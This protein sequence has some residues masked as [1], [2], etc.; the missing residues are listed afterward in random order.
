MIEGIHGPRGITDGEVRLSTRR[1]WLE[2][3]AILDN[4]DSEDKRFSPTLRYL[5]AIHGLNLYWAQ[6]IA[7][8]YVMKRSYNEDF[9]RAAL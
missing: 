3:L 8:F 1:G 6:A 7:A 5:K 9:S 2:W 4:W